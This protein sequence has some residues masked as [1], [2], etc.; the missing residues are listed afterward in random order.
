MPP[1]LSYA[2]P[3]KPVSTEI[4]FFACLVG[5]IV[6]PANDKLDL[7]LPALSFQLQMR[8]LPPSHSVRLACLFSAESRRTLGINGRYRRHCFNLTRRKELSDEFTVAHADSAWPGVPSVSATAFTSCVA[9]FFCWSNV[10][11]DIF[12]TVELAPATLCAISFVSAPT[13]R[14]AGEVDAWDGLTCKPSSSFF[15]VCLPCLFVTCDA[16]PVCCIFKPKL[17]GM[18]ASRSGTCCRTDTYFGFDAFVP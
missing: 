15:F 6:L 1:L 14:S 13:F 7:L 8:F 10:K 16:D 2:R 5:T 3:S 17:V 18:W 4:S 9:T 12:E 11:I